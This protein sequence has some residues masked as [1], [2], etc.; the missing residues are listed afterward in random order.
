MA[1]RKRVLE[2]VKF[3]FVALRDV[4]LPAWSLEDNEVKRSQS[5]QTAADNDT[6]EL[7]T[8]SMI[9]SWCSRLNYL[10]TLEE[11]ELTWST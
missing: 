9:I 11:R 7:T 6:V 2:V 4:C 1:K 10:C 3:G 8:K 5:R